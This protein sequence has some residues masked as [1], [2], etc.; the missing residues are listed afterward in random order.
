MTITNAD[1]GKTVHARIGTTVIV[2]L[3]YDSG[4]QN[5]TIQPPDPAVLA[6]AAAL[7][8][9]PSTTTQAYRAAAA[10]TAPIAATDRAACSP[11]QACPQFIVA[12]KA[13]VIVDA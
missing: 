3:K 4:M 13:T 9:V 1:E 2:A 6:P 10:G 11:G 12:F 5:W 8:P 7:A